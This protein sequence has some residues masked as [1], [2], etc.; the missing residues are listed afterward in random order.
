MY[1]PF[2]F[3]FPFP[4]PFLS[5]H[6]TIDAKW[7]RRKDELT[8]LIAISIS[9]SISSYSSALQTIA[10]FG[11]KLNRFPAM[12]GAIVFLVLS[13]VLVVPSR[14]GW[15]R[16]EWSFGVCKFITESC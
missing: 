3:P 16:S 8:L 15:I 9:I 6:H 5:R 14:I 10:L 2:T 4:S 7:G 11:L 12:I 13:S 1:S